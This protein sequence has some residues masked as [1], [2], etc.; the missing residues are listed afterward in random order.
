MQTSHMNIA[1]EIKQ[2]FTHENCQT[3]RP[4]NVGAS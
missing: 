4:S 3:I 1:N 2:M